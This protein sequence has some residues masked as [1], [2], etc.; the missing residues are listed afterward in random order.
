MSTKTCWDDSMDVL[1]V[2]SLAYDSLETP[3]GSREKMNW[4]VQRRTEAS[5]QPFT[6]ARIA[7]TVSHWSVL[8]VKISNQSILRY[9][10]S[11]LE[12][13]GIEENEGETFRWKGSYHG[14]MAEA[15]NTRL[16]SMCSRV[17]NLKFPEEQTSPKC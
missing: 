2:G 11:G 8:S 5:R 15:V 17:S 4:V 14:D 1:I 7:A 3:M 12:I 13:S 16:I 6:I 10:N 9:R